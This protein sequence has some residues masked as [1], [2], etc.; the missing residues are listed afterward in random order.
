MLCRWPSKSISD[1]WKRLGPTTRWIWS[2]TRTSVDWFG[3]LTW[4]LV[5]YV[6]NDSTVDGT[7]YSTSAVKTWILLLRWNCHLTIKA[8]LCLWI[9]CRLTDWSLCYSVFEEEV[10]LCLTCSLN[11]SFVLITSVGE[12]LGGEIEPDSRPLR[13]VI[14]PRFCIYAL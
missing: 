8:S 9:D 13:W 11:N 7:T 1:K 12:F 5:D 14:N 4:I 3:E 2:T 10:R 6:S